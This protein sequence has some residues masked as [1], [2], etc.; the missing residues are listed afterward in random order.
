MQRRALIRPNINYDE[1]EPRYSEYDKGLVYDQ[2]ENDICLGTLG[3]CDT[4]FINDANL[5]RWK[6]EET[7]NQDLI[8]T[9]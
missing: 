8:S 9:L 3:W 7:V 4:D 1:Q 6:K 2:Y 5:R